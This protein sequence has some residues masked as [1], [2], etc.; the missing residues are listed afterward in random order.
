MIR[1]KTAQALPGL[2]SRF[3]VSLLIA[4]TTDQATHLFLTIPNRG[5][6]A[7]PS[8]LL[9]KGRLLALPLPTP[10][11]LLMQQFRAGQQG[12]GVFCRRLLPLPLL[13]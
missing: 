11:Q 10:E 1:L 5:L 9:L 6:E 3:S 2:P 12:C 13:F 8:L 4:Q 7:L